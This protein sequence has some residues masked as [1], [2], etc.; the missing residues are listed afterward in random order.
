MDVKVKSLNEAADVREHSRG[1]L[2]VREHVRRRQDVPAD[3][4]RSVNLAV[5]VKKI[6]Q[7]Q[8]RP[9]KQFESQQFKGSRCLT[10]VV[11]NGYGNEEL[12]SCIF[13]KQT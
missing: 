7:G 5:E 4:K 9:I 11:L 6:E 1:R 3:A 13:I 8:G 10:S 12:L 2:V